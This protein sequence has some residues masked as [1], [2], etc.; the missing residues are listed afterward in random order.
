MRY[1]SS[2]FCAILFSLAGHAQEFPFTV[3]H[4]GI[5]QGLSN[6]WISAIS[7][8][9]KGYLW[10]ATQYGLNRFDGHEF[11]VFTYRP[12][13]GLSSNW[14]RDIYASENGLFLAPLG[15]GL[16]EVRNLGGLFLPS[17]QQGGWGAVSVRDVNICNG[18][19]LVS[20]SGGLFEWIISAKDSIQKPPKLI[21]N[22]SYHGIDL[23]NNRWAAAGSPGLALENLDSFELVHQH[24]SVRAV[25]FVGQDSLLSQ[26]MEQV[27]LTHQ[28]DDG[29]WTTTILTDRLDITSPTHG[30]EP[31][32]YRDLQDQFWLPTSSGLVCLNA[33][34]DVLRRISTNSL[35]AKAG[36]PGNG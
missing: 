8:D 32:I 3:R 27:Y 33:R 30:I 19:Y 7:Q 13:D 11:E 18:A 5:D 6:E 20:S 35:F 4:F 22:G 34:L 2:S 36:L 10:I 16:Q 14:I 24:G 31:F 17:W 1:L 23:W 26:S 25:S 9:G 12:K 21:S 29:T 28:S 15:Q